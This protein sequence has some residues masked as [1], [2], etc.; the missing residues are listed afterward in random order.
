MRPDFNKLLVER[1][2]AGHRMHYGE[3][4]Q[5]RS[6][7]DSFEYAIGGKQGMRKRH[8]L[9]G[10]YKSFNENL[11]PLKGFL[12]SSLGKQ[13]DKVYSEL[14]KT[15]DTRSVINQHIL[16]HL[17]D[18][19][20]IHTK[21]D[22]GVVMVLDGYNGSRGY[23]PLK[24]RT[25]SSYRHDYYVCPKD[26]TLKTMVK[27]PRRSVIIQEQKKIADEKAKTFREVSPTLHLRLE[28]GVWF[29]LEIRELP[30]V[31]YHWAK[32]DGKDLFKIDYYGH[33]MRTWD[34]LNAQ[35]RERHGI[36]RITKGVVTD[37]WSGARVHREPPR[38]GY[39]SRRRHGAYSYGQPT[40]GVDRYYA[41]KKTAS[42]KELKAAGIDG[43]QTF[44]EDDVPSMSHREASKYR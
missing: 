30:E 3:T 7:N 21:L 37:V 41:I 2:R 27:Q 5:S 24:K 16:E 13:W 26:G 23:V 4:R 36:R 42:H 44:N 28:N 31:E 25:H 34:E 40:A 35:E 38:A 39:Q 10:E 19:V 14:R 33:K 17:F 22:D 11:N 12:H 15:F 43:A 8:K 32:P 6:L 1:E 20:E 18:Y 29:A 9:A